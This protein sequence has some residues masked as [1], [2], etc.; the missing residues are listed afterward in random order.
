MTHHALSRST[1]SP[2]TAIAATLLLALA[3]CASIGSPE[4]GPRDYTP[5]VAVRANPPYG[6]TNFKGKKIELVF[7]EIITLKEQQNRVVVSPTTKTQPKISALGKK[8][9]VEF[10]DTL[11]PGTTY[12]VDFT[13]AIEDN[14]EGNVLDGFSFAFSTGDA[15]DT[16]RVSGVVLRAS[17]LEPMKNVVVGLH[18]NLEDSAFTTLPFDHLSRS[19]DKGEFTI[20]NV[21]PGN[22]HV[23]ALRDLDG[24]YK[25][26]RNEDYA[27]LD[28]IVVPSVGQYTSQD[29]VFTFD[30]KVDTVTTG[31]HTDFLPNNLLLCLFNEDY[32]AHYLVRHERQDSNRLHLKFSAPASA[33]PE[34]D[35]IEPR[36]ISANWSVA[37]YNDTRDSITYWLTDKR[38]IRCD[39]LRLAVTHLR[40]D[41]ADMLSPTTDTLTFVQKGIG[42][43]R[44][45]MEKEQKEQDKRQ[46][47]IGK[48]EERLAKLAAEGKDTVSVHEELRELREINKPKDTSLGIETAKGELGVG[49]SIEIKSTV[50]LAS[51]DI[52]GV[53]LK[54]M[55]P[56]DST[57]S[58]VKIP[59]FTHN[60]NSKLARMTSP[61]NLEPGREYEISIDTLAVTSIYGHGNKPL[62]NTFKV[63]RLDQYSNLELTITG[64]GATPAFV[65]LLDA[66]DKAVRQVEVVNGKAMFNNVEP[67]GYFA[68][69]TLDTNGNGKWDTGNYAKHL[70]PEEVYYL[71]RKIRLRENFNVEVD[72]NIYEVAINRQKPD[73]VKKNKPDNGRGPLS[74]TNDNKKKNDE[75]EDDEFNSNAFGNGAYSGDKYKDYHK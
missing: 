57:W 63:K 37:E 29:T 38:L 58:E 13:D 32:K 60:G 30:H 27:F 9:T 64:P 40:T 7:D 1:L 66:N 62:K 73:A 3:G 24:N 28:E 54:V 65:E 23:F 74:K 10:Q 12:V 31:T 47:K 21:K 11:E 43:V 5:P 68:R 56:A 70:Q 33:L 35:I 4:G 50:P 34:I 71:P 69:L 45:Q 26:A 75:E 19:N 17:D 20:R 67:G 41:S 51:V 53:H 8:I 55:N 72:W 22:Y 52:G 61:A 39:T 25:M 36:G 59:P 46:E 2:L 44:K 15:V 18:R 14:N 48:L 42:A 6:T 49:D 16:L